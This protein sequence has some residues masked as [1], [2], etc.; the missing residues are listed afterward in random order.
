MA[1]DVGSLTESVQLLKD[2][3][4]DR[5]RYYQH[6]KADQDPLEKL[7]LGTAMFFDKESDRTIAATSFGRLFRS[8]RQ[9]ESIDDARA[10]LDAWDRLQ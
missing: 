3:G 5:E 1:R 4:I 7:A 8:D 2:I 10:K 6:T 9:L